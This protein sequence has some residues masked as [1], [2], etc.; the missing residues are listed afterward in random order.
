MLVTGTELPARDKE[1]GHLWGWVA[2][3]GEVEEA[4]GVAHNLACL[5]EPFCNYGGC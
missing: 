1:L 5:Q 3:W 4:D 2:R